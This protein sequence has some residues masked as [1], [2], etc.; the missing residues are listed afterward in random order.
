MAQPSEPAV[1]TGRDV[2]DE[3]RR[4]RYELAILDFRLPDADRAIAGIEPWVTAG[5]ARG[6]LLGAWQAEHGVLGRVY[7]LRGFADQAE[8][9]DERSRARASAAPFG[10]AEHLSD[11]TLNS[12]APFPFMPPV[13][14]GAFGAIYEIRDYH[15]VPGG[16]PATVDGW[17][18]K[19]PGRHAV[20]PI[21]V[22]M[23]A[24]DGPDRIVHIWPFA[25]LDERV[26]V[27]RELFAQ[28]KWPPPG[29]PEHILHASSAM[30]WPLPFSPLH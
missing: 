30:A 7:V 14:T 13:R 12:Y 17:R 5:D 25:G 1:I 19:L 16:L 6:T 29:G 21:T 3:H 20:D 15:L 4:L 10:A 28:G 11:L 8:L 26:E 2:P 27:R 18:Q 9:D 22:V 23:Y 24:L